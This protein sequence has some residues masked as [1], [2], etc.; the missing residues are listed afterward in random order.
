M[1]LVFGTVAHVFPGLGR[2]VLYRVFNP[3][4]I[5][6]AVLGL[7]SDPRSVRSRHFRS[8]NRYSQDL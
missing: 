2:V 1:H 4:V 6:G 7:K 3:Y 8:H 5:V